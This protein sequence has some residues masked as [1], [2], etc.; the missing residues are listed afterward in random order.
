MQREEDAH[1]FVHS[2][3]Q[4]A[5]ARQRGDQRGW[6]AGSRPYGRAAIFERVRRIE[7]RLDELCRRIE[8]GSCNIPESKGMGEITAAVTQL[9]AE[10]K[11]WLA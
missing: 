2:C 8:K 7:N 11:S 6:Q 4:S 1:P 9:C 10:T 5:L 3:R